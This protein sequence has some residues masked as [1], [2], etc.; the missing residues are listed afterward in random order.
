MALMRPL[1][2]TSKACLAPPLAQ[3]DISKGSMAA[4]YLHAPSGQERRLLP[5]LS[6][7]RV[8]GTIT[9]DI[10]VADDTRN[11]DLKGLAILE[12]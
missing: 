9:G 4:I 7:P 12:Q 10:F 1:R 3:G 6:A 11:Y 2:N 8:A 5:R